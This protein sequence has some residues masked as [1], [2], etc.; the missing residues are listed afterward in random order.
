[1][2]TCAALM[3]QTNLGDSGRTNLSTYMNKMVLTKKPHKRYPR[4]KATW[5]EFMLEKFPITIMKA[6][7]TK[8]KETHPRVVKSFAKDG[9]G[10]AYRR[11][12]G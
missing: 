10:V 4:E 3:F 5:M 1:M 9:K 8:C 7:S 11:V 12:T 6:L 2:L